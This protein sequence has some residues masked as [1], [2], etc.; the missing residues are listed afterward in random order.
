M[1]MKKNCYTKINCNSRELWSSLFEATSHHP[2]YC[3]WILLLKSQFCVYIYI[4]LSNIFPMNTFLLNYELWVEI[5]SLL[6]FV[7]LPI[8]CPFLPSAIKLR[9]KLL[10]PVEV[11]LS[12]TKENFVWF[13]DNFYN[14]SSQ[15]L[16]YC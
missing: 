15:Q 11:N 1:C 16:S 7:N 3:L 14:M 10:S 13:I 6:K 2:S 8:L 12:T 5:D 9:H 4:I